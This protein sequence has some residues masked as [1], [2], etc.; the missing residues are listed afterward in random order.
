MNRHMS[1]HGNLMRQV[2]ELFHFL[3]GEIEA[4]SIV[5]TKGQ[6]LVGGGPGI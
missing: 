5:N 2:L 6:V 1:A 4:R 3:G